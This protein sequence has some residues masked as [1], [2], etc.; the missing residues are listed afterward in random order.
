MWGKR[1]KL[2]RLYEELTAIAL[3]NRL[4]DNRTEQTP[5]DTH[6]CAMRE[7]RQQ[8]LLVEIAQLEASHPTRQDETANSTQP[9]RSRAA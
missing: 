9:S 4:D 7:T 2:Q 1:K 3:L 6:A 8:E 5:N